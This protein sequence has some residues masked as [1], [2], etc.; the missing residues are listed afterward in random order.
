MGGLEMPDVV[1][2]IEN[3]IFGGMD[4]GVEHALAD[5]ELRP[6]IITVT[7]QQGV[8]EVEQSEIHVDFCVEY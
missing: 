4:L 6:F 5:Q 1:L 2:R 7:G 8:V 3:I